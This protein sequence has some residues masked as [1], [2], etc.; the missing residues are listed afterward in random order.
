MESIAHTQGFYYKPRMDVDLLRSHHEGLV[1]LS[2]CLN[3]I[4]P[5]A[6]LAGDIKKAELLAEEYLKIF[7]AENFFLEIQA[8]PEMPDQVKVNKALAE[9][10]KKM[11]IQLVATNDVHYLSPD[12]AEAQDIMVCIQTGKKVMETDLTTINSSLKAKKKCSDL[13]TQRSGSNTGRLADQ[14][15]VRRTLEALPCL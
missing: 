8:H 9:L 6:L 14:L 4:I 12:D 2:G 7:G 1:A 13:Q 3:G 10:G 11:G 5:E 15:N